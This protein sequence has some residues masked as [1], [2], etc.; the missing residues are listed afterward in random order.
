MLTIDVQSNTL[1]V[2]NP[3]REQFE[4]EEKNVQSNLLSLPTLQESRPKRNIKPP[5]KLDM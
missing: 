1:K 5:T 4:M 3:N 2:Y